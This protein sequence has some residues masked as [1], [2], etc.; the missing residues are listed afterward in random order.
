MRK[1]G[2]MLAAL[3][4]RLVAPVVAGKPRAVLRAPQPFLFAAGDVVLFPTTGG[5]CINALFPT[6]K[7]LLGHEWRP[8]GWGVMVIVECGRAFGFL[9]FYRGLRA[10]AAVRDRPDLATI[11]GW[12]DWVLPRPGTLTVRHVRKME[13][14][15]VAT[16]AIDFEKLRGLCPSIPS[17]VSDA[18]GDI[19]LANRLSLPVEGEVVPDYMRGRGLPKV[20]SL[21][22]VMSG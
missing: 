2:A 20:G 17:G 5:Q 7:T 1:R 16:V 12:R 3:R 9:A 19:S 11:R 18:V 15:R 22:D 13:M 6:Q 10:P 8:D 14:E 4:A 21:R